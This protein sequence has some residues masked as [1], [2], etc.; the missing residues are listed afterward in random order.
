M[1]NTFNMNRFG[2]LLRRQWLDFGKIYL[3]SLAVVLGIIVGFYGYNIP[4]P[5]KNNNFDYDGNLDMRFRYPLL[6]MLG[7]IFISIVASS[8]FNILGQKS[9]A[10]LELMTPASVLEKFLVGVFYTGIISLFSYLLIFYIADLGFS[11]YLNSELAMFGNSSPKGGSIKE[12]ETISF[13]IFHDENYR[14]YCS[15]FF[16]IPFLI[17]SIFLLGSIYFNRFHFIKTALSV[18]VFTGMASYVVFKVSEQLTKNMT[19]INHTLESNEKENVLLILL[20]VTSLLTLI[21]WLI[22]Y[23]R[24]KEKEV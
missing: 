1:N 21:F 4:S 7:F 10:I 16:A 15:Y 22:T 23:V 2:L 19:S 14:S 24:L 13:Q 11:K 9:R 18:M 20:A 6:L 8:Y 3:I 12:V 17:T 5:L